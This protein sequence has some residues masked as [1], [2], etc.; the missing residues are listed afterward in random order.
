MKKRKKFLKEFLRKLIHLSGILTILLY[1]VLNEHFSH[2]IAIMGLTVLL[3]V[4]LEIEYLRIEH[5]VRIT[6]A[7]SGLFRKHEKNQLNGAV[8]MAISCIIVFSAFDYKIAGLAVSMAVFGDFFAAMVGIFGKKKLFRKKTFIGTTAGLLANLTVG[9]IVLSDYPLIYI[10]MAVTATVI[11]LFT[12]K[13]DDNLTVPVT[14]GFIGQV[15][16][17]IVHVPSSAIT[18]KII[19]FL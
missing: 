7:I 15:L 9:Y 2:R 14:A 10:S 1:T 5:Q 3:I 18:D 4:L 16:V 13:L 6:G 17:Y 8:Y 12:N 19:G 11:E